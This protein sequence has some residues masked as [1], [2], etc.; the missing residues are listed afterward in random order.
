MPHNADA[1]ISM[2]KRLDAMDARHHLL[3]N[4]QAEHHTRLASMESAQHRLTDEATA[5][6]LGLAMILRKLENMERY[7]GIEDVGRT[8]SE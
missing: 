6:S 4:T 7:W 1:I 8:G 5:V 2:L 3:E